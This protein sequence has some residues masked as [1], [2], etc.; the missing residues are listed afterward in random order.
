MKHIILYTMDGCPHCKN[1]KK[2]LNEKNINVDVRNIKDYEEEYQVFVEATES[3]FLPAFTFVET[4]EDEEP[5]VRL[6]VP[7]EDFNSV[8]EASEI[9]ENFLL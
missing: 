2:I 5:N 8:Q 3:E 4:F 1:L 7:D 6:L 9:I